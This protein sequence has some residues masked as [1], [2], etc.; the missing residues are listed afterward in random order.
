MVGRPKNFV[1]FSSRKIQFIG[2]ILVLGK[3]PSQHA[4]WS[5]P[6]LPLSS[7]GRYQ[8]AVGNPKHSPDVEKSSHS[9]IK[10]VILN[11]YLY[12]AVPARRLALGMRFEERV[13]YGHNTGRSDYHCCSLWTC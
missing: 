9:R 6:V 5:L 11:L 12:S 13:Q 8:T 3:F 7:R 4:I 10:F 2:W 1:N